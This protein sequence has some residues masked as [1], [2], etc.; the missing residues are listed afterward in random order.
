MALMETA[1]SIAEKSPVGIYTLK[2]TL[3]NGE[4]RHL[5]E[6]LD[7]IARMNQVMLQTKDMT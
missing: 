1:K 4:R 2:Q 7:Y 6:G 5:G 3:N